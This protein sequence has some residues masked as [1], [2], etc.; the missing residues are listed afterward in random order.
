MLLSQFVPLSPGRQILSHWTT[1]EVPVQNLSL[2]S[3]VNQEF[4]KILQ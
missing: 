2:K 4:P 3:L 1:R